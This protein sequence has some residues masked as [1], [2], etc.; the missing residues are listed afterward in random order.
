MINST[1]RIP[2]LFLVLSLISFGVCAQ[3][4]SAN[5]N[6]T[7]S[8]TTYSKITNVTFQGINNSHTAEE[9]YNHFTTPVVDIEPCQTYSL[10]ITCMVDAGAELRVW[11]D[12]N[13]NGDFEAAE[14][15]MFV[16]L[17]TTD[18]GVAQT[19]DITI[20]NNPSLGRVRM[21][22]V[23]EEGGV[24][25]A[26]EDGLY[27]E[28]EDYE[29]NVI[30]GVAMSTNAITLEGANTNPVLR[31]TTNQEIAQILYTTNGCNPIIDVDKFSFTHASSTNIAADVARA[32][33][34]HSATN[35]I[36]TGVEVG[37][38]NTIGA[39]FDINTTVSLF[40]GDNYFWLVYDIDAN[41][42][43]GNF[44]DGE[45]I[46]IEK[47]GAEIGVET[48]NFN[49]PGNRVVFGEYCKPTVSNENG[50]L[51]ITRVSFANYAHT[52]GYDTLNGAPLSRYNNV[53]LFN[54]CAGGQY[55]LEVD[56]NQQSSGTTLGLGRQYFIQAWFDWNQDGD[57]DD[58]QEFQLVGYY[59]SSLIPFTASEGTV[60]HAINVPTNARNGYTTMRVA[61]TINMENDACFT[62]KYAEVEDYSLLVHNDFNVNNF[63]DFACDYG[64]VNLNLGMVD[65][66]NF[67]WEF[68]DDAINWTS[69]TSAANQNSINVERTDSVLIYRAKVDNDKCEVDANGSTTNY[70]SDFAVTKVGISD[71]K[72]A[73][74]EICVDDTTELQAI[75]NHKS[76]TFRLE[77]LGLNAIATSGIALEVENT[78]NYTDAKTLDYYTLEKVC[79]NVGVNQMSKL[80]AILYPPDTT[81]SIVLFEG[82]GETTDSPLQT[83]NHTFCLTADTSAAPVD[84]VTGVLSGDYKPFESFEKLAKSDI[85]GT[86]RLALVSDT[87]SMLGLFNEFT[88]VFGHNN[89]DIWQNANGDTLGDSTHTLA[90]I[91]TTGYFYAT[92]NSR[93]CS[94]TDSVLVI[95]ETGNSILVDSIQ[96]TPNQNCLGD[97]VYFEA[98]TSERV[99]PGNFTWLV[100]DVVV[101]ADTGS[102]FSSDV[103]QEN[104]VVK[105]VYNYSSKC[106]VS[107]DTAEYVII[108][109]PLNNPVLNSIGITNPDPA[110]EGD[111]VTVE[112][113]V[114]GSGIAT[115]IYW[116]AG[117]DTITN[118]A[119]STLWDGASGTLNFVYKQLDDCNNAGEINKTINYDVEALKTPTVEISYDENTLCSGKNIVFS[120]VTDAINPNA[121][122]TWTINNVEVGGNNTRINTDTLRNNV[123]YELNLKYEPNATCYTADAVDTT[124]VIELD[125]TYNIGVEIKEVLNDVC[126][127]V[128]IE[129]E[130]VN[131]ENPGMSPSYQWFRNGSPIVGAVNSKLFDVEHQDG[132]VITVEMVSSENCT[133]P[134]VAVSNEIIVNHL[135]ETSFEFEV[136]DDINQKGCIG[137]L[138]NFTA[139]VNGNANI[140]TSHWLIDNN[141]AS[142]DDTLD[143]QVS[144]PDQTVVR[145]YEIDFVCK[146]NEVFTDT[147]F[148]SSFEYLEPSFSIF[149]QN[150]TLV[151]ASFDLRE[152]STNYSWTVEGEL[153]ASTDTFTVLDL[154]FDGVYDICMVTT[155]GAAKVC[156]AETCIPFQYVGVSESSN[157]SSL[158][159]YPNPTKG[160]L[161]I[162]YNGLKSYN[163]QVLNVNG[164][165]VKQGEL[166]SLL[167]LE[168]IA[169]GVYQLKVFNDY[170]NQQF[171][172]QKY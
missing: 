107:N 81:R 142:T 125:S 130:V 113:D 52:S 154:P 99:L 39:T 7:Y 64:T 152:D 85:N 162:E 17:E 110:C 169:N 15:V 156:R 14:E 132:D 53:H 54:I 137:D 26:C 10:S 117:N 161:N 160:K 166:N 101:A 36:N 118:G 24:A 159:V 48:L 60:A 150:D 105:V 164:K 157:V 98:F 100:N 18:D 68:S 84:T 102:F 55:N 151:A 74:T 158:R 97:T 128:K 38:T 72:Y 83:T 46:S 115:E 33:V 28:G 27:G 73:P 122:Y 42:T 129:F 65:T 119:L 8:N 23:I 145:Y 3:N 51:S 20:P 30:T 9:D 59:S 47:S 163:Y 40:P 67:E 2:L 41:A 148:V 6:P 103:V 90:G 95:T 92:N 146:D 139:T 57:F 134:D 71:I 11:I 127:G 170:E 123:N 21:R 121:K 69:L 138:Y 29:L 133:N 116:I 79:V 93:Y 120:S 32:A 155:R 45:F 114:T 4:S 56:Y 76:D 35:D 31:N 77:G 50:D 140:V 12:Y 171:S 63:K 80:G 49:P 149:Y 13:Q 167:N 75:Y 89:F 135:E 66:A 153:L 144:A 147:T 112:A 87:L 172:I 108:G 86:W 136:T 58:A 78:V 88:L 44:V 37:N 96:A 124:I 91:D 25:S 143:L 5:C 16:D 141:L 106:A 82:S 61:N 165:V 94:R 168:D 34:L 19:Q 104:D 109:K 131:T 111:I 22:A 62:A 126:P 43:P 70:S 1:I